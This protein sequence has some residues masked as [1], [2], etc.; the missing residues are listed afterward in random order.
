MSFVTQLVLIFSPLSS[1]VGGAESIGECSPLP[2]Q[3]PHQRTGAATERVR[4]S[5]RVLHLYFLSFSF[6][7]LQLRATKSDSYLPTLCTLSLCVQQSD[8]TVRSHQLSCGRGNLSLSVPREAVGVRDAQS[9]LRIQRTDGGQK[10]KVRGKRKKSR[11]V[12]TTSP[13]TTTVTLSHRY[14][15]CS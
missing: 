8:S 4:Q 13:D 14:C 15:L 10:A 9:S 7:H 12:G 6:I 1:L 5:K 2:S 3:E 11:L